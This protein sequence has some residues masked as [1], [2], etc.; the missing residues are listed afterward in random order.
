MLFSKIQDFVSETV[1]E[2]DLEVLKNTFTR[3][4]KP[5]GFHMHTC[6]S[7]VDLQNP[8][9]R[10]LLML[11]FPEQWADHYVSENY[12]QNDPVFR[13]AITGKRAF[14]WQD[15]KVSSDIGQQIFDE[16][17]EF[18]IKNGITVPISLPNE[19]PATVNI[20]GEHD[21]ISDEDYSALHLMA[22]YYFN[23]ATYIQGQHH[24]EEFGN[25]ELTAREKECLYWVAQ[26]KS[27]QDIGD[28]LNLSHH[29][30]HSY[31]EK[32]KS[33]FNVRTRTQAAVRAVYQGVII[34]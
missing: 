11:E 20:I 28:I 24:K 33:K 6:V 10:S 32:A 25:V 7:I 23:S 16:S 12:I 2:T 5:L 14:K 19:Y 13:M 30:V 15:I 34:P 29:T 8:P 22:V 31:L 9:P 4:V 17:A 21:N 26:G 3:Y 1:N 18:G 27:D